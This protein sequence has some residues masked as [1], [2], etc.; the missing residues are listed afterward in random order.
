MSGELNKSN[1]NKSFNIKSKNNKIIVAECGQGQ[2]KEGVEKGG[3]FI[4]NALEIL[5]NVIIE[6]P[7]FNNIDYVHSIGSNKLNFENGYE[8]LSTILEIYN[9]ENNLTVLIGGDHSLG[10][11]SVDSYINIYK[12]E[13]SVLWIDAHADINDSI[14]SITGNIHGMSLGYHHYKRCNQ[15]IWRKNPQK[16]KSYQLYYFGIRDLDP[17]EEKLIKD[18]NIGF[19]NQIDNKLIEFI[20]KSKYLLI[21]FDVDALDPSILNSTGVMAPN[22]LSSKEVKQIIDYSYNTNKLVHLDIMEFNPSLGDPSKS[23]ECIKD[24]FK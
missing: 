16:L 23:I 7:S 2:R 6:Y 15:P 22:G 3:E 11:S 10:I 12:D 21:S 8:R 24:I 20:D 1:D 19:S 17:A 14:T 4:C 5:P 18:E 9:K 13:L